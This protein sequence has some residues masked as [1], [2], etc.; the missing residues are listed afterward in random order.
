MSDREASI[1][2][3]ETPVTADKPD[4]AISVTGTD[5]IS[6]IGS[7]EA[8]T[9]AFYRDIL[10]MPLVLR[11][12]NLDQP[13]VTH[14]FFDTGDGRVLTFFVSDDR[15]SNR[16]GQR[17]GIGAVHHLAFSVDA[18]QFGEVKQ[19]LSDEGIRYNEFN[20]G[21]FHSL[22]TTDH[23]GLV[24]ELATDKYDIPEDRRGEAL[25]AAQ[26]IRVAAGGSYVEDEHL[27]AALE[28]LGIDADPVDL[29]E[30]NSG[31]GGI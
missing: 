11:Q 9:V 24:I 21:A 14:L 19:A 23:N 18:E 5:H 1:T 2:N 3:G 28:E 12:P 13:S 29:P 31:V 7:N 15:P 16:G 20:R 8:D 22:Y 17:P 4:S 26:R 27:E 6:L 30:A 10:G 25:A